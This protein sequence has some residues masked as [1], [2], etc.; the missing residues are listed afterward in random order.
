MTEKIRLQVKASDGVDDWRDLGE[1][2]DSPSLPV[3]LVNSDG[4][5]VAKVI[6]SYAYQAKSLT[7]THK[8]YFFEDASLNWYIMRK[9]LATGVMDYAKG[10]GGYASVYVDSTSA[11][12]GSPTFASYGNTF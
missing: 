9:T 7:A 10:T 4:E 12:S 6:S 8:Y 5:S 3:R 1:N 2:T 11:P